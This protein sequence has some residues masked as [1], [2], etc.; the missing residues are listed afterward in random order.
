[1]RLD[2]YFRHG[3]D[4]LLIN[5]T[6]VHSMTKSAVAKE[7]ARTWERILSDVKEVKGKPAAAIE[8]ARAVQ[9]TSVCHQEAGD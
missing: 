4:E 8:T 3:T 6:I 1:M 5:G 7:A 9:P 2:N